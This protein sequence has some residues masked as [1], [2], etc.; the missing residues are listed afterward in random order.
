MATQQSTMDFLLD[1]L[2]HAGPMSSRK[3]FGEY[4]L[5]YDGTPVGL[6]CD[7]QLYLKPTEAG[8]AVLIRGQDGPP[9]E[10]AP[11]PGARPYLQINPDQW[12]DAQWL[13]ELVRTTALAL[14]V[15]KPV[16][17]KKVSAKAV[18]AAKSG[19]SRKPPAKANA[20][21]PADLLNLGPKSTALLACEAQHHTPQQPKRR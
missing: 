11:Y 17:P 3:M 19:V 10:G 13:C 8:C 21:A 7:N 15:K 20:A 5:Y 16:V 9:V 6:V 12:E 2:A 18:S 14:P 4:C 1:Q